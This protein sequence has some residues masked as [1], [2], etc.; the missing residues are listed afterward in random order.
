MQNEQVK[1]EITLA[2]NLQEMQD[3]AKSHEEFIREMQ[4]NNEIKKIDAEN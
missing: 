1:H 4:E 3:L 2:K